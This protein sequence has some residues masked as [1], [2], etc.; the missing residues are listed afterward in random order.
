MPFALPTGPASALGAVT[1]AAAAMPVV[2][3]R[4]WRRLRPSLVTSLETLTSLS[5]F[6]VLLRHCNDR[7][8]S[9]TVSPS[10]RPVVV[11]H[12]S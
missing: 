1:A 6:M 7:G 9:A 3:A 10:L 12:V 2:A 8:A 11:G 4:N 5:V